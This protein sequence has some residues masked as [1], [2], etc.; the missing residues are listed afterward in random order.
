[1]EYD[2]YCDESRSDIFT[3]Q[4]T[5]DCFM[6]IGGLWLETK[7]R[8]VFKKELADLKQNNKCLGELKWNKVS[9]SQE[10][11]YKHLVDYFF[12]KG[13]ELRFRCIVVE[14]NKVDLVRYHES[15]AELSFYKFYYQ[16]LH[17]WILDFNAYSIFIDTKS[18][19]VKDRINVLRNCL[20]KANIS[21][22]IKNVQ[23][24]PSHEVVFIQLTD[25]L[26]GAVSASFNQSI[27][28]HTKRNIVSQIEKHLKHKILTPTSRDYL[29]FNVFKIH[30]G[31][32]W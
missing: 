8:N 14:K 6:I 29:K 18:N 25:L 2:I 22:E 20:E 27:V 10:V 13:D 16:L 24:L 32:D 3:S 1:M 23:A 11:F 5:K 12:Q 28:S 26:V 9:P 7:N 15:D 21:S 19:R 31:G 17:H 4:K 30:P